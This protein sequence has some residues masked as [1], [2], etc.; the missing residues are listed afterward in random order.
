MATTAQ[1]IVRDALIEIGVLNAVDPMGAEDAAFGLSK[2]NRILD[3]WNAQRSAVYASDFATFT[4]TPLLAPHTIG[5]A[6]SS[7]TLTVTGNRPVTIEAANI[8]LTTSTPTVRTPLV[9]RDAQWW[10]NQR[11]RD[12]P[13]TLPTD[14]FYIPN[15]P[16]GELYFWPVPTIAYGLELNYRT[17]LAQLA[18]TDSFNLPPGYQDAITLT[19]AEDLSGPFRAAVSGQLAQKAAHARAVVF[20]NNDDSPR[21]VTLDSGMQSG[22][23]V[24]PYFNYLTGGLR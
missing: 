15:W 2:L 11:V 10:A 24:R 8:I 12:V 1:D 18:L 4:L 23:S 5:P 13:T 19:L 3:N 22:R 6:A 21:L 7:P 14:L 17:V 20:A 16:L 9:L